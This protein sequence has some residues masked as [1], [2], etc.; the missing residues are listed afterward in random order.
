MR[1]PAAIDPS[2]QWPLAILRQNEKRIPL[3]ATE[4]AFR[5]ISQASFPSAARTTPHVL[6]GLSYRVRKSA[7]RSGCR[8][9]PFGAAEMCRKHGISEATYSNWKARFGG[10]TVSDA[11]RLK[12][13]EQEIGDSRLSRLWGGSMRS[14]TPPPTRSCHSDALLDDCLRVVWALTLP[15][16]C[17]T[18][19]ST[20]SCDEVGGS[21]ALEVQAVRS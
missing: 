21:E 4:I 10:M 1:K 13:L 18:N 5:P 14:P 6:P 3:P 7:P 19:I 9:Y 11:Q 2:L 12:E 8:N 16:N 15:Q 17:I 20:T